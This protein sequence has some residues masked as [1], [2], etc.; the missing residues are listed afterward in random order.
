GLSEIW[1]GITQFKFIKNLIKKIE[2]K[3]YDFEKLSF[4]LN[5][6][7]SSCFQK[8]NLAP[9]AIGK[10]DSI[11]LASK[12][13]KEIKTI[14]SDNTGDAYKTIDI[15]QDKIFSYEGFSTDTSVSFTAQSFKTV[16]ILHEDSANLAIIS[17]LLRSLYLHREIREKGGAYGGF[18]LYNS[19][20]GI[21]SF[22]SYR[23]PNIQRTI[24][25]YT[26]A[27]DFIRQ[28]DSYS[29]NDIKEAILQVCAD[30]DKPETPG[31]ASINAFYRDFIGLSDEIRAN[32]KEKLLS[33]T[34]EQIQNTAEKY[35]SS[36]E[37]QNKGTVV[38]S[39][40]EMLE[41]TNQDLKEGQEPYKII[42]I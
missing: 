11:I 25:T 32:F 29:D 1:S 37:S 18:A 21:F 12:K 7:S 4:D 16:R 3:E 33:T 36:Y 39:S 17:R 30:I 34:K 31:P 20:N 19:E 22:A 9:A 2:N 10:K 13:I 14:L 40:K 23:D 15:D 35:F 8:D 42:K 38:I 6:I 28:S 27:C 24:D 41:K 26:K 5:D